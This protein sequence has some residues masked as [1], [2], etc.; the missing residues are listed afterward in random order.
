MKAILAATVLS[1]LAVSS[2][3]GSSDVSC[4]RE[5]TLAAFRSVIE[6]KELNLSSMTGVGIQEAGA[7]LVKTKGDQVTV[8]VSLI[9]T[10]NGMQ[11]PEIIN[12]TLD[13]THDNA[14]QLVSKEVQTG[15]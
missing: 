2:A 11:R 12:V 7:S 14:C 5:A 9:I 4:Q 3:F 1:T 6:D 8:Q 10:E 15:Y 13:T